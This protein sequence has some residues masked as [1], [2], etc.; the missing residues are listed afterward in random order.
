M[1]ASALYIQ[2][3]LTCGNLSK[4]V[5]STA[6]CY[7]GVLV[8]KSAA[9]GVWKVIYYSQIYLLARVKEK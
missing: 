2:R 9:L 5:F 1:Y 3:L 4:T 7:R 8:E 6:T